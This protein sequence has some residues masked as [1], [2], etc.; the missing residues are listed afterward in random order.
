MLAV[1]KENGLHGAS[2]VEFLPRI[3]QRVVFC[4]C[5]MNDFLLNSP[6]IIH[7]SMYNSSIDIL[8]YGKFPSLYDLGVYGR[9][10]L[11]V[12]VLRQADVIS[13]VFWMMTQG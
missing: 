10:P 5:V 6:S 13:S 9:V 3:M 2:Y 4:S 7:S 11:C 12:L 8:I 1:D